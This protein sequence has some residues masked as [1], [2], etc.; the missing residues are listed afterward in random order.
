MKK[1]SPPIQVAVGIL[2]RGDTILIAKRPQDKPYG[3]YWEFPGGKVEHNESSKMALF[4]E[5]YEE[6]DIK[7]KEAQHWFSHI[8]AYPDKTV[9]LDMWLVTDFMG[10]PRGIENQILHWAKCSDLPMLP[11]LEGNKTMVDRI[12]ELYKPDLK[13]RE[14]K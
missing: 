7:I 10:E 4:R 13:K 3:R 11:L 14:Y 2:K 8:H 5:L 6:L 12:R 1:S 9:L